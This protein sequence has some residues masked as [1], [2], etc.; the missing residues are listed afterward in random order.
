MPIYNKEIYL[1]KAIKSIQRQSLKDIEIIAI[2]DYSI[3]NS[4]NILKKIVTIDSRLKIINNDKNYGLLYSRAKGILNSK[5]E[6]V[7]NLD[8]DDELLGHNSLQ[9]LYKTA[10][11]SKVDVVIFSYLSNKEIIRK[12]NIYN[13]NLK[14]PKILQIAFNEKNI[15]KDYVFWNKLIKKNIIIK[16][17][18]IFKEKIN[19][20]KWNF[21]ED[22]IWSILIHKY[23]KSMICVKKVIY[24]YK[25]YSDSLMHNKGNLLELINMIYRGE[26]FNKIFNKKEEK[27]FMI[28]GIL[29]SII[30]FQYKK[31][32]SL[33]FSY[34]SKM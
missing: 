28:K 10:K 27:E 22:N 1:G 19:S 33:L 24:D 6:F 7:M 4:L 16:A 30:I 13:S 2:N 21:H 20:V 25:S 32:L 29:Q 11:K 26:M 9:Y 34:I 15:L 5:G 18:K 12:C 14:Q 31:F 17:Y 23:A 8:P 3:D